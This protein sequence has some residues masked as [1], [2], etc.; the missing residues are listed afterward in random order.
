MFPEDE[1]D[2]EFTVDCRAVFLCSQAAIR[3]MADRGGGRIV[4]ISSIAGQ[5]APTYQIA[6]RSAKAAAIHFAR[7]LAVEVAPRHDCKLRLP[8]HDG[9]RNATATGAS[10]A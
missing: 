9:F 7:C 5:I 6:Y 8:W 4:I 10:G 3:R 2:R 1:W